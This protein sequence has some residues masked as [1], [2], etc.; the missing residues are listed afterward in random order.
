MQTIFAN[1]MG[2]L[3]R[4]Y[5]YAYGPFL[6]LVP[7]TTPRYKKFFRQRVRKFPLNQFLDLA[8]VYSH[9]RGYPINHVTWESGASPACQQRQYRNRR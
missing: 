2:R 3:I 4:E 7:G 5:G 9:S 1:Q 6:N 8:P